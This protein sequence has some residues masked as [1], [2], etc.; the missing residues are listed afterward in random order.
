MVSADRPTISIITVSYNQ[1]KFIRQ[2]I[3]SVLQQNYPNVEHVVVDGGSTDETLSILKEY[4]HLV[5]VSE[6]DRG[7]SH[8]LNKGFGMAKGEYLGWINSDD[9]LEPNVLADVV[10]ALNES[11]VVMGMCEKSDREGKCLEV[12]PNV[13]RNFY[14]ILKYW[15]MFSTP[16]QPGVFF[17]RSVLEAVRNPDGTFIDEDLDYCMD[18][19]LWLRISKKFEFKK[20]VPKVTSHFR[21]YEDSKTGGNTA[22]AYRETSRIFAR[23]VADIGHHDRAISVVVPCREP[24]PAL[25]HT[26]ESLA[27]Q[28]FQDFEIVVVDYG[29]SAEKSRVF[30]KVVTEMGAA[31]KSICLRY[32]KTYQPLGEQANYFYAVNAAAQSACAPLLAVL[33]PGAVVA[34]DFNL[35]IT[36]VFRSDPYG[37]ALPLRDQ[38]PL[39]K[40]MTIEHEGR[41]FFDI[42]SAF[43]SPQ[44]PP[45]FVIRTAVL[46][47]LGGIRHWQDPLLAMRELLLRLSHKSWSISID[48]ILTVDRS[49]GEQTLDQEAFTILTNYINAQL[50]T[51][52][53]S[54]FVGDPFAETRAKHGVRLRFPEAL[55]QAGARLLSRAPNTW[56]RLNSTES[57]VMLGQI[58][59]QYPHFA[60]GWYFLSQSLKNAGRQAEADKAYARFL[61]ER[62]AEMV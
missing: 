3:E 28:L 13:P 34:N 36:D 58:T 42:S 54:D 47:E 38:E 55:V 45:N 33:E 59:E 19:E 20:R 49:K 57:P 44:L 43:T 22:A 25:A 17:R 26:I 7:Q 35:L 2:N 8:A 29:A 12:N 60:P 10:G 16:D 61:E 32:I 51:D 23:H 4:P 50:I 31:Y 1:G 21:W 62:K 52:V 53:Q 14:D 11:P 40:Q 15:V 27:Q 30:R 37:L 39:R 56:A 6:P 9:W 48:N 18:V 46:H 41:R 24:T 5:W